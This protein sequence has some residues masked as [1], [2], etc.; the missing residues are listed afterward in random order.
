MKIIILLLIPAICSAQIDA[1]KVEPDKIIAQVKT[2]G[3][4]EAQISTHLMDNNDTVYMVTFKDEQYSHISAYSSFTLVGY[5][6]AKEFASLIKNA[7]KG[8]EYKATAFS[9]TELSLKWITGTL[10]IMVQEKN[11]KIS[12][13]KCTPRII[14]K[15]DVF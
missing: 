7:K 8:E 5:N 9:G 6:S 13:M 4:L 10:Y 15:F 2:V 12:M 1:T 3:V 11:G 14:K